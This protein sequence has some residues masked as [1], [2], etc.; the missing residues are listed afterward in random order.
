MGTLNILNV[1]KKIGVSRF[2]HTSTSEVYGTAQYVPIDESHPINTQSPY[3]ASKAAADNVAL[4][5]FHS[6]ELPVSVAR[7]FNTFGPRQSMRAVIPTIIAQALAGK[8]EIHIGAQNP[9][10]DFTYVKDTCRAFLRMLSSEKTTGQ[11]INFGSGFEIP[12]RD[13]IS[14][15]SR[16]LGTPLEPKE[17]AERLRPKAAEVDR[18]LAD[19]SKAK[20]L[21][22]WEPTRGGLSGFQQNLETTI[23]WFSSKENLSKYK[24]EIYAK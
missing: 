14:L 22:N 7:P 11:V 20:E 10:R 23:D 9:T 8:T 5:Y 13:I 3:A 4:S 2:I 18:L 21:M 15:V 1:A 12:I 16:I 17:V 6:F 19:S 24:P